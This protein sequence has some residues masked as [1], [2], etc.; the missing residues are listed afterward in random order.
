M[1]IDLL[2]SRTRAVAEELGIRLDANET[3]VFARQ[4]EYI[5]QQPYNV[6]YPELKA[7]ALIPVDYSVDAAATSHTFRQYDTLGEAD[8]ID[9]YSTDLPNGE[10]FG[11][12]FTAGVKS[13]GASYQYSI[14]DLRAAQ[15]ANFALT[16]EKANLTRGMI[17]TK[18]DKVAAFGDVTYNLDGFL[19]DRAGTSVGVDQTSNIT[20]TTSWAAAVTDADLAKIL[21]DVYM[22]CSSVWIQTKQVR[23]A[24]TLLVSTKV[25]AKLAFSKINQ[26]GQ[27]SLLQYILANTPGL[28]AIEPW[29]RLD[30][31]GA[32][33]KDRL[34]A[35]NK[36]PRVQSLMICQEFEQF[37]PQNRN[38]AF[39][40]PCHLR[41]GGVV[42][43]YPLAASFAD[44][45]P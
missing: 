24:D 38:L 1:H 40:I 4:L 6:E 16:A 3:Q 7:R 18:L 37:A 11:K 25:Y 9:D 12:E 43:R 8:F 26:Y 32:S 15:K 23:R 21:N 44:V 42:W 28:K 22:L 13:L 33:G 31:A 30:A 34:F 35:Y 10:L 45:T 14:Q 20:L 39:T 41:T 2:T 27:V 17:E 29:V 5:F 36:D 19:K